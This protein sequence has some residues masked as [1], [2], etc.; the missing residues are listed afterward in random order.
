LYKLRKITLP[1]PHLTNN[2]EREHLTQLKKNFLIMKKIFVL[3]AVSCFATAAFAQTEQGAFRIGGSSNLSFLNSK[4][5]AP[6]AKSE[7]AFNL[8]LDAGYFVMDNL[9]VNLGVELD[10]PEDATMIGARLG[11]RYYFPPKIFLG[12]DFDIVNTKPDGG[13]ST[14]GTGL[15]IGAGYAAFVSER[16]AIEPMIG[17]RLGLT[18]KDK[19]TKVSG[20]GAQVGLGFYF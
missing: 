20:F 3:L 15:T 13:S 7:S 12:A 14:S 18:D 9:S 11:L 8:G 1:L 17:Y 10:M 2:N 4:V 16:F 6:N 19:G 5:D